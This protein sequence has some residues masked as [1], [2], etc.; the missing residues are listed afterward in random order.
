MPALSTEPFLCSCRDISQ[1]SCAVSESLVINTSV[2]ESYKIMAMINTA[3]VHAYTMSAQ[4]VVQKHH[5][6]LA[7]SKQSY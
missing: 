5:C 7:L 6:G 4:F 1:A 3:S 2:G